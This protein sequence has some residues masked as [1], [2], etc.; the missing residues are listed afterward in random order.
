MKI[1][2]VDAAVMVILDKIKYA[3]FAMAAGGPI[4]KPTLLLV[5]QRMAHILL[6]RTEADRKR[7]VFLKLVDT[8]SRKFQEG[9]SGPGLTRGEAG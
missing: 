1:N 8:N 4:R 7:S 3:Q 5:G 9:A 2:V 6:A